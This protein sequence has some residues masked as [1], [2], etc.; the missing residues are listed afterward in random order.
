MNPPFSYPEIERFVDK[1]LEELTA[2][3][4]TDAIAL[5]NNFSDT[6]W[7]HKAALAAAAL[8]FTKGRVPFETP[9]GERGQPTQGQTFFYFG[10]RLD[11][12][13]AAFADQGLIMCVLRADPP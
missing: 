12:F 8:C 7:F 11:C 4:V 3:R 5:T 9:E 13:R 10:P 2:G 6:A 1:L